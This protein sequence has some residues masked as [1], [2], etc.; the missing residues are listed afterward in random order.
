MSIKPDLVV[1][2]APVSLIELLKTRRF[3]VPDLQRDY[4]WKDENVK[5]LLADVIDHCKNHEVTKE[6]K[7]LENPKTY[8]LGSM[9]ACKPEKGEKILEIID[10]QQRLTTIAC[11]SSVLKEHL[12]KYYDP[13]D[14]RLTG[15]IQQVTELHAEWSGGEWAFKL[16]LF[17][18][19]I[20]KFFSDCILFDN[21]EQ[22]NEYY[23]T[24][25]MAKALLRKKNLPAGRIKKAFEIS[26]EFIQKYLEETNNQKEKV[27][28]LTSLTAVFCECVIVLL[29]ESQ[30]YATVYNLF[31]GLNCRGMPLT[32]ADLVKNVMLKKCLTSDDKQNIIEE[33]SDINEY[34]S[35]FD[36]LYMPDFLHVSYL[37]RYEFIKSK[38]LFNSIKE[39]LIT[40]SPIKIS[41]D[42]KYDAK[43]LSSFRNLDEIKNLSLDTK[44]AVQDLIDI[45]GLNLSYIGLLAAYRKYKD[46]KTKLN[47]IINL[48]VNFCFRY[49]K[50]QGGDV[51][52]LATSMNILSK[53]LSE[54]KS[55]EEIAE[56]LRRISPD[57]LFVERFKTFSQSS[58]ELG[59]YII[60]K[61]EKQMLR[62]TMPLPH[63]DKSHL[64]HI[65]PKN[66]RAS[67]W[68]EAATRK[69]SDPDYHRNLVWR[70]GNLIPLPSEINLSIQDKSIQEKIL[71]DRKTDYTHTDLVS[72][73]HV[74]E[75]LID[76]KWNEQSILNRQHDLANKY[77]LKAWPLDG[78]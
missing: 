27:D 38:K 18:N 61:M 45:L 63:G 37:S 47:I 19:N 56:S 17:D 41:S 11:I 25:D 74:K 24:N 59:Y 43:A 8:F 44:E 77:A 51:S 22:R 2:A 13:R 60:Y 5:Q 48:I 66:P 7:L 42:L 58:A 23:E 78:S 49:M 68:P 15:C 69:K 31:E 52:T 76:G 32:S 54:N 53:H 4:V 3:K 50:I 28:R 9:V 70:I 30:D 64:E 46:D 1:Q 16:T 33:W 35:H 65:M 40:I 10:G 72:P 34:I 14:A 73:R 62:G 55:I 20:N 67:Y 6:N 26:D 75:Y 71:N 21:Q 12:K 39:K 57:S 36:R 29:I